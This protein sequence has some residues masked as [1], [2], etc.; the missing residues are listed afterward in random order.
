[1]TE[2]P[3]GRSPLQRVYGTLEVLDLSSKRLRDGSRAF[4]V[5]CNLCDWEG[6]RSQGDL[7]RGRISCL[8][9]CRDEIAR[10]SP[11][12]S[13]YANYRRHANN[14]SLK[15]DLTFEEFCGLTQ[16]PCN[17]CKS[18]PLSYFHKKGS[19]E[20]VQ[21]NGIDRVDSSNDYISTNCVSCCKFCNLAKNRFPVEEFQSWLERVKTL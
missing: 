13:L 10:Q 8:G 11:F 9:R 3:S 4:N 1:M 19:R 2:V 5:R 18:P 14:R 6:F 17:Y 7:R 15:F 16:Q 12:R 21:Y 20:G